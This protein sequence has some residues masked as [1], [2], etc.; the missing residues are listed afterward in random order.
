[1]GSEAWISKGAL[2][3]AVGYGLAE[4]G[5]HEERARGLAQARHGPHSRV[6]CGPIFGAGLGRAL[7]SHI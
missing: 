1:M 6:P 7:T 5:Q 3:K 4:P 2:P